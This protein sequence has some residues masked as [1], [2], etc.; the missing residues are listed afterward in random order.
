MTLCAPT[1]A[2]RPS[3]LQPAQRQSAEPVAVS[4]IAE[5]LAQS[6]VYVDAGFRGLV[7]AAR[8]RELARQIEKTGINLKVVLVTFRSEDRWGGDA[9]QFAG[10]LRDRLEVADDEHL[11]LLTPNSWYGKSISGFEWPDDNR[12][13]ANY[14]AMAV[15]V[16]HDEK[17]MPMADQVRR[18]VEIIDAGT[19]MREYEKA[20]E[21]N[22][23]KYSTDG[24][25][26]GGPG[27]WLVAVLVALVLVLAGL[28][29]WTLRRR[30]RTGAGLA[31]LPPHVY[32]A[33]READEGAV[34]RRAQEQVLALGEAVRDHRPAGPAPGTPSAPGAPGGSG[35]TSASADDTAALRLALDAYDSAGRVLDAAGGLPDLVGALALVIEGRDALT[36]EDR[37]R[38]GRRAGGGASARLPAHR[39]PLCF[40]HPLHGRA[41]TRVNWRALGSREALDVAACKE[42][43]S[44]VRHRRVPEALTDRH[45]G[46]SV[47]YFDVPSEQSLWAAT[48]YGS[49]GD[50]PLAVRVQ[51]GDF[52]RAAEARE[53]AAGD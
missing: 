20:R 42:C 41:H 1:A 13:D 38:K 8:Q 37:Q 12:Y 52:T 31:K 48:G 2:A 36:A 15:S 29:G 27:A 19:G 45:R 25:D 51:R 35:A 22:P 9:K 30:R 6:P 47:P 21:D 50:V 23:F 44:A 17:R 39:L 11:I 7:S 43:A 32:L 16:R 24:D 3:P 46:R 5:R 28:L 26:G 53:R 4:E 34:R 33:A 18:A 10:A 49:F 40:F 14:A